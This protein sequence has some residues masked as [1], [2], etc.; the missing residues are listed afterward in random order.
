V[1]V[2]AVWTPPSMAAPLTLADALQPGLE[3]VL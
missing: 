3:R 1:H 2:A